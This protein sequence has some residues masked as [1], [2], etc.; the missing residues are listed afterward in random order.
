MKVVAQ[1]VLAD[2]KTVLLVKVGNGHLTYTID[3]TEP[4]KPHSSTYPLPQKSVDA[5]LADCAQK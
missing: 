4:T 3:P 2:G 5:F 1:K